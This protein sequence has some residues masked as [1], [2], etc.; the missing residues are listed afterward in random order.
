MTVDRRAF[1]GDQMGQLHA[2]IV[3]ATRHSDPKLPNE[4][5]EVQ[6]VQGLAEV[7][8]NPRIGGFD[9]APVLLDQRKAVVEYEIEKL[10]RDR[11]PE[12]LVLLYLAGQAF[13]NADN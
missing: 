2:L 6:Q 3:A 10:L 13:Q 11:D 1:R 9:S 5:A 7:L 8:L 4:S 12:D